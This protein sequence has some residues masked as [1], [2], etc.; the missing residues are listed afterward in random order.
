MATAETIELIEMEP[1]STEA[2]ALSS[3][4]TWSADCP[5]WQRD[6][7]R[8]LCGS[9][10][11][12]AAHLDQLLAICKGKAEGQ[13]LTA[14]HVRDP[15]AGLAT[16]TLRALHSAQ[17]VNAIVPDQRLSF[18]KTGVTVI[19]GDNGAGKSGYARVLKKVCRARSA[20]KEE[21]ILTNIY[22]ANPGVPT[23][24]IDFT[25]N[26]QNR[27]APWT[28][29]TASEPVL[30]A[31]SVFDTRT[32]NVHVSQTNDVAY[33]PLPLKILAALAQTC[34]DIRG[35]LQAEIA[36]LQKQ[37]PA[38]ITQPTCRAT[39]KVGKLIGGL[40]ASTDP[41]DVEAL[42]ALSNAERTHLDKLNGDLA[43]D[44][45][46][47]A[48]RLLALKG[49]I[50]GFADSLQSFAASSEGAAQLLRD[51]AADYGTA[52]AAAAAASTALFA[53]EPLPNIGSEV[54]KALWEAARS[55]SEA[56][57]YPGRTFPV[58]DRAVCV[59][60]QQDLSPEAADRMGRFEAF[61][62]D[63]SKKKEAEAKEAYE[64]AFAIFAGKALARAEIAAMVA[65]IRD[66]LG[67]D[68]LAQKVR[69]AALTTLRRHRRIARHHADSPAAA[70]PAATAPPVED[71]RAQAAELATRAAGLTA[72]AG[73]EA[74]LKLIAERDELADRLW[75]EGIKADVLAEIERRKEI[76]ALET[77][78][79]D[80]A[81]NRITSKSTEIAQQVVTDALRARFAKEVARLEIGTL[82]VELKQ[83][84]SA[85]GI[86]KFK[87]ALTRKPTANVGEVLSE[88]EHRCVALAAFL[89]E[90]ATTDSRSAIVFDDPVSSLDHG[91]REA[92]AK[93]LAEEGQ[94]RQ[95]V[96]F[97]HDIA[98]VFQLDEECRDRE[99]A[100]HLAVRCVSKG[101]DF[102]GYCND[103][104]P[105]RAMPLGNVIA[106]MQARLDNEK[107]HHHQGNQ[108]AWET[109]VRGLQ[110]QLRTTWERAV[111]EAV[112]PVLRR[113]GNKVATGGLAKMTAITLADCQTMREA[114]GR[115]SELL[116]SEA[117]GLNKP[118]PMP[119]KVQVEIT[120]LKDWVESIAQRQASIKNV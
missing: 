120:A 62:K 20:G 118:L 11:L 94:H 9:D 82:A 117:A 19:Y 3:I 32:A 55:Y 93:R 10:K 2:A 110:E 26:G 81:T 63:E 106:A 86:P 69:L 49:K 102:A 58:I 27:S 14:E 12:E 46:K 5:A 60:C 84:K 103:N 47:T 111:E 74:R 95:I 35:K 73:S 77:A 105:M 42:A 71:L 90:L 34:Q 112:S 6:A 87:V 52:R 59:L 16:V 18:D 17:H 78:A 45:A 29:G 114:F 21:G 64:A 89:A 24:V 1:Q 96:V 98:F 41:A 25:V 109:T 36:A 38:A 23:A 76:A 40:S 108:A 107:V 99:P 113:L 43:A 28:L 80:T 33:T 37:T 57:A 4:V 44:P 31:V 13:P 68:P 48:A 39:T 83:E 116:H 101:S 53:D 91:H 30:S 88:G 104:P 85:F 100:T 7:L 22:D 56:E 79:K 8:R 115:C 65:C 54:W 50:E 92:I 15:A 51:L 70:Y 67:D 61:V 119:D 75:L 72:E 97:T 66:E